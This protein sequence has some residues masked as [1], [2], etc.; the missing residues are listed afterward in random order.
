MREIGADLATVRSWREELVR[1]SRGGTAYTLIEQE[2]GGRGFGR[3]TLPAR[4]TV[5]TYEQWW[6]LLGLADEVGRLD[7][8][9]ASTRCG[10]PELMPWLIRR[11]LRTL[12]LSDDWERLLA[13][14]GWLVDNTGTGR[15]LREVTAPGVDTKFVER[16]A[17][18]LGEWL[19][20]A[21]VAE[22]GTGRSTPRTAAG[23]LGF[24]EPEP[25]V[26]I[27]ICPSLAREAEVG[28]RLADAAALELDRP[29]VLVV[30][31]QVTYLSVPV[32]AGGA[33]VWGHGFDAG[34]LGRLPWLRSAS[35]VRYWGDLDTHGFA[36]LN[37]FRS[38]VTSTRSVLMDRRTLLQHRDRW[39]IEPKPTRA[40]LR[41]LDRV[42]RELYEDLAGGEFGVGVRLEQERVDWSWALAAL[43]EEDQPP[44]ATGAATRRI[45]TSSA[46]DGMTE[47]DR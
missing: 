39:V 10:R 29:D 23:R 5:T 7:D 14:F 6:R 19:D 40:E 31:N 32:P 1:G 41:H 28:L 13:A 16:H 17:T 20:L 4:V 2:R 11:P 43:A 9:A 46:A 15:Y 27:R 44:P 42:D 25:L 24:L 37:Q 3:V 26:R 12:T 18:V 21:G 22:V 8:I 45:R 30:E 33:V 38:Q 35:R 34:R 36:I 47:P